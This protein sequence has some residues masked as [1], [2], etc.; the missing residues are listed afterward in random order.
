MVIAFLLITIKVRKVYIIKV[1]VIVALSH[2]LIEVN[3]FNEESENSVEK[4][5]RKTLKPCL[6]L[7][8]VQGNHNSMPNSG[9]LPQPQHI[10]HQSE[11]ILQQETP[12]FEISSPHAME[13]AKRRRDM[14]I[15]VEPISISTPRADDTLSINSDRSNEAT[16][17]EASPNKSRRLYIM[18]HGERVDFTFGTW[19]PY[20][21]DEF[22]NYVRKDLNM[23][24][25][26]PRRQRCPDGWQNDSPLTNIGLY[27]AKLT[28]EALL[29]CNARI[30]HVYCSPAYR[31]V[32][33]CISTLEGLHSRNKFKV[34]LE[35][36]LF[37]WMAW[38]P[39]GVPDWMSKSELL[40]ADYN[41]DTSYQPF[42]SD[43]K[44]NECV[45]E[46]TEE[47][48]TRNY[49]TLRKIIGTTKG[50]ILIVAH[51]TTLDT[52]TRQLIGAEPRST[53]E[54]RQVIHKIPYCSLGVVEEM[55]TGVWKL[56]EPECLPV[57]HSKNP[58]FEWNVL[59]AT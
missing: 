44:L 6:D 20:C 32:Q 2:E 27:Q 54:L 17:L 33:T 41:I 50:N 10:H 22:N 18:R 37:E 13:V 48:Y 57:T 39:D 3:S 35:P 56:V 24:R 4:Y 42:I 49:E 46:T 5:L 47:F 40:D 34:K 1:D 38:Y 55:E 59:T 36:G 15:M 43:T 31:C 11:C 7:P 16:S 23:P 28:G 29:E 26:L 14:E 58:R 12:S 52:C 21:F 51:A 53:N 8:L 45:K 19:I 25:K 30:D 9:P